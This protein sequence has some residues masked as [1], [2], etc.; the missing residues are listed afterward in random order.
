MVVI[1]IWFVVYLEVRSGVGAMVG[2]RDFFNISS[3]WNINE[4]E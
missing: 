4:K 1:C 2:F 3:K